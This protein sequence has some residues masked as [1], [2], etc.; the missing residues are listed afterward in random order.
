MR[1]CVIVFIIVFSIWGDEL[2]LADQKACKAL[3]HDMR[4]V[5]AVHYH[6]N[7][8]ALLP[9]RQ[10]IE[11]LEHSFIVNL[12]SKLS[13]DKEVISSLAYN[14]WSC[15]LSSS[16]NRNHS[17]ALYAPIVSKRRKTL[18]YYN[19]KLA[20]EKEKA[21]YLDELRVLQLYKECMLILNEIH[22]LQEQVAFRAEVLTQSTAFR[23]EVALLVSGGVV[24]KNLLTDYDHWYQG[25]EQKISLMNDR[26]YYLSDLLYNAFYIEKESIAAYVE[27]V[28]SLSSQPL[29]YDRQSETLSDLIDIVETKLKVADYHNEKSSGQTLKAGTFV[30]FDS[31]TT[32]LG[33][34]VKYELDIKRKKEIPAL[35]KVPI[36]EYDSRQMHENSITDQDFKGNAERLQEQVVLALQSIRCGNFSSY[37]MILNRMNDLITNHDEFVAMKKDKVCNILNSYKRLNKIY[38]YKQQKQH[39]GAVSAK[40]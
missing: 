35:H 32:S 24:P 28:T 30:E 7:Q 38:A 2:P 33:L 25:K 15:Q 31:G 22:T 27:Y 5:A 13:R 4:R 36:P 18:H 11:S 40:H 6:R 39:K 17:V 3:L 12:E 23:N 10:S 29:V 21:L 37:Y 14:D 1:S 20:L 34:Q 16:T 8:A 9:L 26:I 19:K